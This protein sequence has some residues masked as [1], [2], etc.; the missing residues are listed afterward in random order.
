MAKRSQTVPRRAPSQKRA[1]DTVEVLLRATE[2]AFAK[3]GFQSATTN[4]IAEIAGVSIGTLYHY[5]PTKEALVQAIVERQ[6]RA[7]LE[8]LLANAHL[9]EDVPLEQAIRTIVTALVASIASRRE[10][11]GRWY[12]EAANL[13][14]LKTGLA[15]TQQGARIVER[16]LARRRDEVIPTDLWFAAELTVITAL[17][18]VRTASRDYPEQLASGAL[19]EELVG[20]LSRYLLKPERPG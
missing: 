15:L 1:E 13:G 7:E 18:A 14:D 2:I 6:W 17:H 10:L 19:T 16:A 5:F 3:Y 11:V 4:R 9:L 8:A 12:G 20:M